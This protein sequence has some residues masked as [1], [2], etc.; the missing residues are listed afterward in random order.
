MTA[1]A[2]GAGC[3][4]TST[5][6]TSVSLTTW[7][8]STTTVSLITCGG[9]AVGAGAQAANNRLATVTQKKSLVRMRDLLRFIRLGAKR[10]APIEVQG[11]DDVGRGAHLLQS[12]HLLGGLWVQD[13]AA[14]SHGRLG[15]QPGRE[16]FQVGE[17]LAQPGQRVFEAESPDGGRGAVTVL[18]PEAEQVGAVTRG[19]GDGRHCP[20][21]HKLDGDLIEAC[22]QS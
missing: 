16:H 11:R 9:G 6:T 5:W 1:S 13:F 19:L 17:A 18:F 7:V 12:L 8:C 15:P 2:F 14:G 20:F 22:S 10:A 21:G 4:V 3:G